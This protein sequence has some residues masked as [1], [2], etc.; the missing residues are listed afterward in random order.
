VLFELNLLANFL[1]LAI[2]RQGFL[3][4]AEL[5][6]HDLQFA[7]VGTSRHADAESEIVTPQLIVQP[8]CTFKVDAD[9][10]AIVTS[11]ECDWCDRVE[12]VNIVIDDRSFQIAVLILAIVGDLSDVTIFAPR[13]MATLFGL[14]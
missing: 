3:E 10:R 14:F 2:F 11:H 5:F 13:A 4:S 1:D 6:A 8:A 12:T 7:Q 9:R